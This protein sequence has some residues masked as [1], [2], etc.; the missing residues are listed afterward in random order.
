MMKHPPHSFLR[1]NVEAISALT[2]KADEANAQLSRYGE[3]LRQILELLQRPVPVPMPSFTAMDR[4][5]LDQALEFGLLQVRL[6][7]MLEQ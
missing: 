2:S 3:L 6:L 4:L 5:S 1:T 7:T